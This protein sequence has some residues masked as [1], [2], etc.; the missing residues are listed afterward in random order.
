MFFFPQKITT[1]PK[2][3]LGIYSTFFL[4]V[5]VLTKGA[6]AKVIP[7]LW[8][9]EPR[10]NIDEINE[11]LLE[12]SKE[13]CVSFFIPYSC[14]L[15]SPSYSS[16][17]SPLYSLSPQNSRL[18]TLL[19]A[20]RVLQEDEYKNWLEIWHAASV[21]MEDRDSKVEEAMELMEKD[22][23]LVTFF[24]LLSSFFS[25]FCSFPPFSFS[26]GVQRL[27]TSSK[28]TSLKQLTIFSKPG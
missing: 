16:W 25:L 2:K 6:D 22:L 21:A 7:R 28:K 5:Q 13:G 1:T 24:S 20:E 10:E 26:L 17:A 23:R 14:L 4:L 3:C 19:L 15:S 27:K 9:G 11:R 8:E 12:Y 18:R